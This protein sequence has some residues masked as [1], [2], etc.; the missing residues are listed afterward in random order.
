MIKTRNGII[1]LL[2]GVLLATMVLFAGC[3]GKD[4]DNLE[5]TT[6]PTKTTYYVGEYFDARGMILVAELK[7]G[8]TQS[9]AFA[10]NN[11]S[12]NDGYTY[13]KYKQPLTT[14]DTT[15]TFTYKGKTATVNITVLKRNVQAPTVDEIRYSTT[16]H[17]ITI[18]SLSGAEYRLEDGAWQDS[19]TFGGLLA[20]RTYNITVRY[21]ATDATNASSETTVQITTS[22]DLQSA[23]E[24]DALQI[25]H[26]SPTSITIAP[27]EGAEYS[28]DGGDTWVDTNVF[29]DLTPGATYQVSVRMKETDTLNPSD[30]TTKT[31]VMQK[32]TQEQT[33]DA[34]ALTVDEITSTSIALTAVAGVEYRL[35]EDG[36]WQA[37]P[38]F[39]GL[40][41][42]TTYTIYARFAETDT[43][44]A[45]QPI[46][47]EFTTLKGEQEAI[48]QSAVT[49]Q[50]DAG[51]LTVTLIEG[52]EYK[53]DSGEWSTQN[54]FSGLEEGNTYTLFVRMAGTD[55]LLASAETAIQIQL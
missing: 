52:A 18:T 11:N 1:T 19:S 49:Y 45:S 9:I 22:K 13:D 50:V 27:I 28:I 48:E 3:G 24:E 5:V 15:I 12:S 6:Q 44:Y 16:S 36:A 23:I 20:G 30:A 31:I 8:S 35:G 32:L 26:N 2:A 54:V 43:I 34:S 10:E 21:K 25:T 42:A 39:E 47:D 37:E 40:N 7:D 51:V 41:Y 29:E 46:F 17:S 38:V 33:P 55:T 14:E 4:V 53:L